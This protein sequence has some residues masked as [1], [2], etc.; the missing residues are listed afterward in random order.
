MAT[1]HFE[2][3]AR[4]SRQQRST[5]RKHLLPGVRAGLTR[6]AQV[7]T[8]VATVIQADRITLAVGVPPHA[9][10]PERDIANDK[11][12][13]AAR[14][15]WQRER[16]CLFAPMPDPLLALIAASAATGG[17]TSKQPL[18]ESAQAIFNLLSERP[19]D[20]PLP[21]AVVNILRSEAP[22][23]QEALQQ[24]DDWLTQVQMNGSNLKNS[25]LEL[26]AVREV[27]LAAVRQYGRS[28]EYVDPSLRHDREVVLAAVNQD[29]RA[30]AFAASDLQ[31][32][33]V[34]WCSP[35]SSRMELLFC[36][37][38][39]NCQRIVKSRLLLQ[40]S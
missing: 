12:G 11:A 31:R 22:D 29:G 8:R 33:T 36:M 40:K 32:E 35:L 13:W 10:G 17:A 20:T 14:L 39:G 2:P 5:D 24:R 9:C 27:V 16:D 6:A 23:D 37:R 1:S 18:L 19:A 38:P 21:R 34:R 28:L 7:A 4:H 15:K 25:P 3:P 26:R 30:I